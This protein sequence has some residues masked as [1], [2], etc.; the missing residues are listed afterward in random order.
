MRTNEWHTCS[1]MLNI[2]LRD[3]SGIRVYTYWIYSHILGGGEVHITYTRVLAFLL[4]KYPR[5]ERKVKQPLAFFCCK[6]C[7]LYIF[8]IRW[9][10]FTDKIST[11]NI[12][13]I[14]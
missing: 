2:V 1:H 13:D 4:H 11:Y 14:L 3:L 5:I 10:F 12:L 9:R 7:F 6:R 8:A